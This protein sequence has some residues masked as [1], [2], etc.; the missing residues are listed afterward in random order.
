[1][2]SRAS[3]RIHLFLAV[4]A[5]I[6]AFLLI[7]TSAGAA[8]IVNGGFE[9][10]SLEGWTTVN[11][12]PGLE[13]FDN[14]FVYSGSKSPR[15]G[16]PVPP[17]PEGTYAAITDQGGAGTHI[18]YQDVSLDPFYSHQLSL[19]AYYRS[20]VT[21]PTT[22]TPDSLHTSEFG[23]DNQQY[24]I[25]VIKPTANIYSLEA[26]D[27]LG[28]LFATKS[29]DPKELGPT[30]YSADLTPFAGQTVRLRLAEVDNSGNFY[31]GVDAVAIQSTPPSNV[32][33]LG[34]PSF[35]KQKGTA[36]LPVAVP[37]AGTLTIADVKTTKRRI[38]AKTLT[39]TGPGT[40]QL[41]VK[42]TKRARKILA[43]KGKLKLKVAVTFTPTGGFPGTVT[44]KLT[45]KLT[46][47]K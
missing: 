41:P 39:A 45:L 36:K 4:G 33:A 26:S 16:A 34:K 18:L 47:K 24:R 17:P 29:G 42:P 9:A 40:L 23:P 44:R 32:V 15:G 13:A 19:I 2:S 30:T 12:P 10:G 6:A 46:P 28:T 11:E 7:P 43:N 22:P 5:A 21:A 35:N 31:A 8:A 3:V 37:G 38:K 20:P 14:W 27:V 25:D 1:M